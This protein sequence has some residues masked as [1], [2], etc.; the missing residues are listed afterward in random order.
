MT[1]AN[2]DELLAA[3]TPTDPP[4]RAVAQER[5]DS[6]TKPPGSLGRL[7]ELAAQV[8]CVQGDPKPALGGKAIV[9]MAADHG[10]TAQGVSPFPREVTTQMVFNFLAGGAA[11]NQ[12]AKHAGA[13]LT[14]VDIGVDHEFDA[15]PDLVA[16][17]VA[18][19]TADFSQGP[20]MTREEATAAILVGA[21]IA[22]ALVADGVGIVGTGD[23]GI[24]NT[25]A[26]AAI[27][28]ALTGADP[29]AVVGPGTGLDAAGVSRKAEFVAT[30]LRVNAVDASDPLGVLAAVGG[31]EIAGLVGVLLGAAASG[32]CCVADGFISGAA[33]LVASR[34][35]P[36][37]AD[38]LFP[39]HLS[40]E[41][42]ARIQLEAL[43]LT[44]VLELDMRLGEGTG[45]ALAIEIVEAACACMSGMA[46]F[47]EAG[48]SG[49]E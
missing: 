30:A 20:A 8:A 4:M 40:A 22:A 46:T 26:A 35:A 2:L 38:H 10:V 15:H 36:A 44:P 48:V 28:A 29:V 21:D 32:A 34:M 45:A 5:L 37:L 31:L 17:K 16:A 42:G 12:L 9:L 41:P 24:G 25:T 14:L 33:A 39:S 19:G 47:A 7:E 49:A 27:T 13:R 1:F 11:I 18:R 23:M 43:G 6:L 3:V